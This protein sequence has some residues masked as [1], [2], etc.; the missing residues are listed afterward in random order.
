[1]KEIQVKTYYPNY[2]KDEMILVHQYSNL[3]DNESVVLRGPK[4]DNSFVVA[5]SKDKGIMHFQIKTKDLEF[6]LRK[7]FF[8]EA[9]QYIG[10]PEKYTVIEGKLNL[11]NVFVLKDSNEAIKISLEEDYDGTYW[12]Y[13]YCMLEKY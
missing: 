1:M 9:L 13:E 10:Y 6:P 11:E 3:I 5:H 8:S 2:I 4:N 7:K 12:E